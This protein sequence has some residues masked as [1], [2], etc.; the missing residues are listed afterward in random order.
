MSFCEWA[1]NN[2][3]IINLTVNQGHILKYQLQLDELIENNYIKGLG[4]SYRREL[5]YNIPE[6]F[7]RYENTVLHVIAG[8]DSFNDILNNTPFKK[9][10]ILGEKDFG[11]NKGNV[12]TNSLEHKNWFWWVHKMFSKFDVVSFDNLALEQLNIKRFFSNES[13]EVFNQGEHS[14][15]I[16]AVDGY[17]SPSSRNSE[18][19]DWNS[20]TVKDFFK[21]LEKQN[22]Y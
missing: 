13:W 1:T 16:S 20:I 7:R 8:I 14:M 6:R 9:V 18:K 5:N 4:I 19:T 21:S 3:F 2:G 11:F 17:F 15:Y 22:K 12:N 10:L